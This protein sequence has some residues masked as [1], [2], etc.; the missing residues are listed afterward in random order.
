M[1]P[2]QSPNVIDASTQVHSE[3]MYMELTQGAHYIKCKSAYRSN[4]INVKHA[5][6]L[7]LFGS[8]CANAGTKEPMTK[9]KLAKIYCD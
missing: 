8:T 1:E 7:Y 6:F 3:K 2:N 5:I 9:K 4:P